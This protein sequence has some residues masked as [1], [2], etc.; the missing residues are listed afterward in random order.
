[1][2][3][4]GRR[5]PGGT[6][7]RRTGAFSL[8][9]LIVVLAI[10]GLVGGL[11]VAGLSRPG[12]AGQQR[13]SLS[14]VI[15]SLQ[16]ARL[17]A[18]RGQRPV[19]VTIRREGDRLVLRGLE[20]SRSF[21]AHGITPVLGTEDAAVE[22]GGVNRLSVVDTG[23]DEVAHQG[24][25][26]LRVTFD[27]AGRTSRRLWRFAPDEGSSLGRTMWLVRFEVVS[28]VPALTRA[29]VTR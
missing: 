2:T 3:G 12:G 24:A 25:G 8:L 7:C 26:E 27:S 29:G 10:V 11:V 16:A 13:E 6:A 20:T 19:S 9:E 22:G 4:G 17:E 1:M 15:E 23:V 14:S 18:M 21:A 5:D 28:G